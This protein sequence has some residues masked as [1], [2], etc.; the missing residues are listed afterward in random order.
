MNKAITEELAQSQSESHPPLVCRLRPKVKIG[1]CGPVPNMGEVELENRSDSPLE[2][3]YRMT[4]LQYLELEV[5]GS[6]GEL[7]SEG[8]F[9]DRFSPSLEPSVLRLMPG[10]KFTAA[11]SLLAT[12]PREKRQAGNYSVHAVYEY[13]GFRAVSDPVQVT[14]VN[15]E[16]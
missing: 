12:V 2:I 9:S 3:E 4:P 7:V 15:H 16:Q 6:N 10:E 8:Y 5:R 14:V 1:R 11:V 13:N